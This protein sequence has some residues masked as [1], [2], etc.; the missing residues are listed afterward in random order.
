MALADE[1]TA[2]LY[3]E[4]WEAWSRQ[5]EH[6]HRVF[7]GDE[8]PRPD[9]LKGLLNREARAKERYD[10]ARLRLLGL[11]SEPGPSRDPDENPFR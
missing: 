4:A 1:S 2:Q 9:Q 11:D 6:L 3:R 5:L 7:L 8:R 10:A